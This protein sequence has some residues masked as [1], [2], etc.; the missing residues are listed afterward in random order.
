MMTT[1][2]NDERYARTILEEANAVITG[3]HV[4][5]KSGLHGDTYVNKDA[6]YINPLA[7]YELCR[8]LANRFL[9]MDVDVVVAPAMG[10]IDLKTLAALAFVQRWGLRV[11]CVYA[12]QEE[13]AL[14]G[15]SAE[16][17]F[18]LERA[19]G[20]RKLSGMVQNSEELVIKSP[21]MALKRGYDKV[22]KGKRALVLEDVLNTGK[23]VQ[24]TVYATREA[25]AFVVGVGS[26]CNRSGGKVT[27]QSLQIPVLESLVNLNLVTH[28]EDNCP[29]C[30]DNVPINTE[31]G[32]GKDF[33]A[34]QPVIDR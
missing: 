34:R 22:V 1:S 32:H 30:M 3:T 29:L 26:I 2:I 28:P 4:V 11:Q 21:K 5:Y 16:W 25:G 31:V 9:Y 10:G 24:G 18:T 20:S 27:A 33:L 19:D 8:L 13:H 15:D 23:S 6:I 14:V 12:Q 17:N 7:T